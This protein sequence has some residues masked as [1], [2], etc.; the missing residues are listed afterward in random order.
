MLHL[1]RFGEEREENEIVER[2]GE[3]EIPRTPIVTVV[4]P[5]MIWL[6]LL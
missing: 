5:V 2:P 6:C 3:G 1:L 4:V